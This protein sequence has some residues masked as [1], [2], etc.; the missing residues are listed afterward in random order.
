MIER[1]DIVT[2]ARVDAILTLSPLIGWLD[3]SCALA[4]SGVP[5][6]VAVRVI[7]SP[8]ERRQPSLST[9]SNVG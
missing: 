2:A 4:A 1:T 3:L 6:E 7:A 8:L 5:L 9:L